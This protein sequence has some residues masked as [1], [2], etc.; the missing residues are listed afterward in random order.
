[1]LSD[2]IK[3]E[4]LNKGLTQS[5]LAKKINVS[6]NAVHNWETGK[7][8]PDLETLSKISKV[9]NIPV[10]KLVD[11]EVTQVELVDPNEDELRKEIN[12]LT[13]SLKV[14]GLVKTRDYMNDLRFNP[15]YGKSVSQRKPE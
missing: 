14:K 15:E 9:L 6:Q 1:M 8:Q 3:Q 5:E 13:Y 2:T 4:R 12:D 11:V 10:S 7:R